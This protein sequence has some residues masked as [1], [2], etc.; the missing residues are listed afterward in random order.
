M[1]KQTTC[2]FSG[3]FDPIH[4]GHL[5]SI[6]RLATKYNKVVVV[7]LD[8]LG[9]SSPAQYSKQILEESLSHC[10]GNFEVLINNVHFGKITIKQ[11][12]SIPKFDVYAAGNMKV[13]KHMSSLGFKVEW[14]DRAFHYQASDQRLADGLKELTETA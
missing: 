4:L 11:L 5:I 10:K 8:Y 2:L 9:R 13:L 14:V 12:E 1:S 6:L 3:R 7:I